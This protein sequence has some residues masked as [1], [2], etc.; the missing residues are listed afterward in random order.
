MSSSTTTMRFGCSSAHP[1]TTCPWIKRSST[2]NST[3]LIRL[4]ALRRTVDGYASLIQ[5]ERD[6]L[7]ERQLTPHHE[8]QKNGEIDARNDNQVLTLLHTTPRR[9]ATASALQIGKDNRR[10]AACHLAHL[11]RECIRPQS[12]IAQRPQEI[13]IHAGD[14]VHG[15]DHAGRHLAVR[16]DDSAHA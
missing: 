9:E 5:Q 12:T 16:Y 2:R 15:V 1:T 13:A 10:H 3:M 4:E 11:L 14:V 7:V 8:L 6:E